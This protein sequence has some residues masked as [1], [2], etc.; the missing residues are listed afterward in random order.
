L[1]AHC[2]REGESNN[3]VWSRGQFHAL[4]GMVYLLDELDRKHPAFDRVLEMIR[5]AGLGLMKHQDER[6]GLWRNVVDH[7]DARLESSGT[8]GQCYVFAR[9]IREGW[10][11]RAPFEPMVRKAWQAVKLTYWR[12]G[13]GANCR[14]SGPAWDM[15]YYLGRP[16]GWANTSP[17]AWALMS[18][19]ELQRL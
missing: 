15:T 16:H 5:A 2:S 17:S 8:A 11:D 19:L 9:C 3:I 13:L 4:I 7:P 1:I 14:G 10:L 12:G 18:L 6:T